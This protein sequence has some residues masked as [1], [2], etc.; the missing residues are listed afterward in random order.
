MEEQRIHKDKTKI[1]HN[2]TMTKGKSVN[3]GKTAATLYNNNQINDNTYSYLIQVH[4]NGNKAKHEDMSANI[5]YLKDATNELHQ[6]NQIGTS[7]H[8]YLLDINTKGSAA[9]HYF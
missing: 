5:P 3:L 6:S 2:H 9:K 1:F 8:N 4:D 7:L